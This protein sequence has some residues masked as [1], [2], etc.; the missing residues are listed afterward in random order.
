MTTPGE[1]AVQREY[2]GRIWDL[3]RYALTNG[4]TTVDDVL[5]RAA[6][7]GRYSL[8]ELIA[9]V[10]RLTSEGRDAELRTL[11]KS[12]R[13]DPLRR[14]VSLLA[15]QPQRPNSVGGATTLLEAMANGLREALGDVE[16]MT[17]LDLHSAQA[18]R[19]DLDHYI[20][21]F[22]I[23][24]KR[25]PQLSLLRANAATP[26]TIGNEDRHS[27]GVQAWLD[28]VNRVY[29][30]EGLEPIDLAPGNE[31][32]LDRLMCAPSSLVEAGPL[33]TVILPT[34]NPGP[35][36]ATALE[37]L[38]G[39]SYRRL[40][41][42]IMDDASQPEL[43]RSLRRWEGRDPRIAVVTLPEN[44]G[45]YFARNVAVSQYAHGDYITVHDD[46]DWSHPRKIELQVA[47]LEAEP[48]A[49]ANMSLAVRTTPALCF[50]RRTP[51]PE[52]A[53]RNYSSL[54]IRRA[55]FERLGYWD[56][57]NRGADGELHDRIVATSGHPIPVV[58]RSPL[59]LVR[60][61][62]ESLSFGEISKGYVDPRRRWYALA[63]K[64]WHEQGAAGSGSLRLPPDD[65]KS[66]PFPAPVGM[67]G[68]RAKGPPTEVDLLYATDFRFPDGNSTLAC[69]EIDVLLGRGYVVGLLQLDSP[70]LGADAQL[71]PRAYALASHPNARILTTLDDTAARLVI[72]RHPTVLQFIPAAR[73][74]VTAQQVVLIVN[75]PPINPD[76]QSASYDIATVVANCEA[77][78]G[79][80]PVVAPES[81]EIR[82]LLGGR[83]DAGLLSVDDWNGTVPLGP[84]GASTVLG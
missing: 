8:D 19:E 24:P 2:E 30:R 82:T 13:P 57:V 31:P 32:A 63:Y 67:L 36:L 52:F 71:H 75:H 28:L 73:L 45:T 6:S 76:G 35:P 79:R 42:L 29:V 18:R 17:L 14:V 80:T 48:E 41:I 46:D 78:F 55:V 10:D 59:S 15:N 66:R 4:L 5:A 54:M 62:P 60:M 69:N 16:M 49:P 68:S 20:A 44:R 43:G 72:V 61:M 65:S 77:A 74:P 56:V 26:F 81:A 33:V 25:A 84:R 12:L 51:T 21:E 7:Q 11:L 3:Y 27:P 34:H 53:H 47:H 9:L 40:E 58:G 1:L 64:H 38:L 37:S 39:Q 22:G 23:G 83:V 50:V 70:V